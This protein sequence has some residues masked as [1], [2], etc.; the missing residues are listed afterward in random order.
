MPTPKLLSSLGLAR[1]AGALVIGSAPVLEAIRRET[2]GLVLISSDLSAGGAKKLKTACEF[3][4]IPW[5]VIPHTMSELSDAL[6]KSASVGAV[7]VL[8][9]PILHLFEN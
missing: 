5:R 6:G 1:K 8:K 9:K 3:H 7:A 2:P 4:K